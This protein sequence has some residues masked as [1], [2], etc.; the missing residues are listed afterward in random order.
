MTNATYAAQISPPNALAQVKSTEDPPATPAASAPSAA[1]TSANPD[2]PCSSHQASVGTQA[3]GCDYTPD[4]SNFKKP[5]YSKVYVSGAK[6]N[7]TYAA[8][9]S[10]PVTP[11]EPCVE[12]QNN[13][14]DC[15]FS[16]KIQ[17]T[18]TQ[19]GRKDPRAP[20]TAPAD[21]APETAAFQMPESASSFSVRI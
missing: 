20:R 7:A 13:A 18:S 12:H 5:D 14:M 21:T 8:Q 10:N 15:S 3:D 11:D 6:T 19:A 1:T 17:A 2:I 4:L 9:I 16:P